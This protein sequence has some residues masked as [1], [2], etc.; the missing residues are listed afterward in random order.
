MR[1]GN[2]ARKGTDRES[3][4]ARDRCS[5]TTSA[6]CSVSTLGPWRATPDSS[7]PTNLPTSGPP[8]EAGRPWFPHPIL[9]ILSPRQPPSHP[10]HLSGTDP[11]L[12]PGAVTQSQVDPYV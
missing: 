2:W 6:W 12:H 10:S 4:R 5:R 7:S 1:K 11:A 8:S 3:R 9:A